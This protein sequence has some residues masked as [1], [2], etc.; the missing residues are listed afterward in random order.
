VSCAKMAKPIEMPFGLWTRV[1]PRKH[2][3]G[4]TLAPPG[5]YHWPVHNFIC[6]GDAACCLITLS[7]CCRLA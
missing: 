3:V 7:S 1:G 5:I 2:M 6:G 4:V